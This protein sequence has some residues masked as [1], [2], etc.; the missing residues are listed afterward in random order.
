MLD[1]DRVPIDI[2]DMGLVQDIE[3]VGTEVRITLIQ[4]GPICWQAANIR[5]AL[6]SRVG[7]IP[8]VTHV[9]V[10]ID[11]HTDWTPDLMSPASRRMLRQLRPVDRQMPNEM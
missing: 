8:G 2:F 7:A 11:L 5:A 6:Q 3:I 4:T 9:T 1:C 10:D